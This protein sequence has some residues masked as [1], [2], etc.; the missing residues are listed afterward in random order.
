MTDDPLPFL[1]FS[2]DTSGNNITVP[3]PSDDSKM[4]ASGTNEIPSQGNLHSIMA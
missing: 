3:D 1:S 4:E 2:S